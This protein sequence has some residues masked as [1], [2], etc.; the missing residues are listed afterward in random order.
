MKNIKTERVCYV[1]E[2]LAYWRK[3]NALH[4]WFIHNCAK[5]N[6]DCQRILVKRKHLE[7][8]LT[9]CIKINEDNSQAETLLPTQSGFFF[10]STDYD[11]NYYE[12]VKVTI[13]VLE[14]ILAEPGDFYYY[15]A[16]W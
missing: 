4:S 3:F 15:Q 5:G 8:L 12:D 7:E 14:K 16:S 1:I 11:E 13:Q 2:K 9:I 6:D 10:G